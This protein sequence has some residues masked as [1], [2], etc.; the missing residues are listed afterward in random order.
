MLNIDA[1]LLSC[2]QKCQQFFF[3]LHI[4]KVIGLTRNLPVRSVSVGTFDPHE[5]IIANRFIRLDQ[6]GNCQH[7]EIDAHT[8]CKYVGI[9]GKILKSEL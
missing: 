2:F 6:N 4:C 8:R 1:P 5:S 7:V 3:Y 9:R